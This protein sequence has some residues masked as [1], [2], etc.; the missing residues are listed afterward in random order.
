M[1]L[2]QMAENFAQ[3]D[4]TSKRVL[5]LRF[6]WSPSSMLAGESGVSGLQLDRT[7]LTGDPGNQSATK[8]SPAESLQVACGLVIRSVGFDI[9]PF[10]G[11]P[12]ENRRVPH[13]HGRVVAPSAAL[14]GLYVSGWL[15][16]GPQGIIATNIPDAQDTANCL[17]QDLGEADGIGSSRANVEP[18]NSQLAATGKR[19][20]SFDDWER[21][22]AEERRL[23][24][25]AGRLAVKFT[26]VQAM[27]SVLNA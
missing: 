16:R 23:G 4:T 1:G 27:L 26:D 8:A 25:S 3:K 15:K 7:Q 10:E 18:I 13:V 14:G 11:L 22:E 5:W 2:E 24:E 6:L 9:T 20:V 12:L 17:M 19:V 21:I